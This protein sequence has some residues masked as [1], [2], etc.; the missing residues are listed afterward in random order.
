MVKRWVA[1]APLLIEKRFWRIV[2]YQELWALKPILGREN[3]TLKL[4]IT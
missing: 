4:E 2:G 1:S 3:K